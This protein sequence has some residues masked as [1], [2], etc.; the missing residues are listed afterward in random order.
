MYDLIGG[1]VAVVL[2]YSAVYYLAVFC[3]E[4][5]GKSPQWLEKCCANKKKGLMR[6][7]NSKMDMNDSE[8]EMAAIRNPLQNNA[9]SEADRI[10]LD[11]AEAQLSIMG[12]VNKDLVDAMR[13][14]KKRLE[15]CNNK[16]YEE[17]GKREKDKKRVRFNPY[18]GEKRQKKTTFIIQRINSRTRKR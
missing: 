9:Q 10:K 17:K 13:L 8:F 15:Q 2:V 14:Q 1:L 7:R 12:Q 11:N 4:V 16:S 18:K 3:S 5:L 6:D